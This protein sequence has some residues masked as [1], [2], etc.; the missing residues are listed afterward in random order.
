MA[1]FPRPPFLRYGLAA[2]TVALATILTLLIP[3]L[4]ERTVFILY[5]VAVAVSAWYGGHGP[6]LFATALSAVASAYFFLDPAFSVTIGLVELLRLGVF[7][8]VALL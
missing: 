6:G 5:F 1:Q 4:A 2:A 3:Q 8:F 7:V